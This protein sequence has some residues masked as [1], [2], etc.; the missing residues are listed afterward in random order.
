MNEVC[1]SNPSNGGNAIIQHFKCDGC[2]K[3]MRLAFYA[4]SHGINVRWMDRCIPS[5]W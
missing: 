5:R 1:S 3:T 4:M 2:G